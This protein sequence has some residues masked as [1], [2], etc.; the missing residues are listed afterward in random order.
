MN[1]PIPQAVTDRIFAF[2]LTERTGS[3][4]LHFKDGRLMGCEVKESVRF[5]RESGGTPARLDDGATNGHDSQ[6][7]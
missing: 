4:Q 3:I 7:T 1:A 5:D 6:Q 2:M